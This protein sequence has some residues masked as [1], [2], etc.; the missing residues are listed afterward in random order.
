M[1]SVY[2]NAE[3]LCTGNTSR[4]VYVHLLYVNKVQTE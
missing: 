2:Y 1:Q 3:A 4:N